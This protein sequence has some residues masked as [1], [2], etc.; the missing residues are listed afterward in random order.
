MPE[1]D[2][3]RF[4]VLCIACSCDKKISPCFPTGT[5]EEP[6]IPHLQKDR[7]VLALLVGDKVA[8]YKWPYGLLFRAN[9][10]TS[11][12]ESWEF[13]FPL[14]GLLNNSAALE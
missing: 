12:L 13:F 7:G 8:A 10:D 5:K 6:Y 14:A 9:F 2:S 4:S 1:E 3:S 11:P